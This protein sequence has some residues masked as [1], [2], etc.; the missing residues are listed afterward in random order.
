MLK[1]GAGVTRDQ[2]HRLVVPA[3]NL[4]AAKIEVST[5]PAQNEP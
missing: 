2:K 1:G 4:Q 5:F 3:D